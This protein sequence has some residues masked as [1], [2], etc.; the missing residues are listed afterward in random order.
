MGIRME[1]GN[2]VT[3]GAGRHAKTS[4]DIGTW[5]VSVQ[6]FAPSSSPAAS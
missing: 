2:M 4:G 1:A 3:N 6:I 5:T